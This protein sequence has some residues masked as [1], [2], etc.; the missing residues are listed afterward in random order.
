MKRRT[1]ERWLAGCELD[2]SGRTV[3]EVGFGGAHCLK[4]VS[5]Q[6][7]RSFGIEA[8]E[9]NLA[10][11]RALDGSEVFGFD[12]LPER[13][14]APVDLW[15]LLDSFEHLPEPDAFLEWMAASSAAGAR[16]LVV[17]PEA[18]SASERALGRLWPH[19]LPDHAF[20]WSRAGLSEI[21]ARHGFQPASEFHPGKYVSGAMI[22]SHVGHKF[23]AL[24]PLASVLKALGGVRL[25]FN[26]GQ[27]GLTFE[28]AP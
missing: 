14:P 10:R 9:E 13:L 8:V 28:K 5:E 15:L 2:V 25:Y 17:A 19:K 18:D 20:H 23:P 24:T 12:E 4:L 22:A 16:A 21:F 27:M 11:A 26:V 6:A 7:A 1:L 3:C